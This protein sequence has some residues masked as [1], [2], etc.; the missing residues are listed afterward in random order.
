MHELA[1]LAVAYLIG[2][3]LFGPI[4]ARRLGLDLRAEGSG[5]PGATNMHRAAGKGPAAA[6]LVLDASK[7]ACGVLLAHFAAPRSDW[8]APACVLMACIGH[9]FP[10]QA[11]RSGGKGVSTALGGILASSLPAAML[12][13]LAYAVVRRVSGYGSVASLCA[14]IV[15]SV[16]VVIKQG[17]L[18]W[19]VST[20][21]LTLVALIFA[22]HAD[23]LRRL[24]NGT[25]L[26]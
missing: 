14:I 1:S 2:S 22:R 21:Y 4:I 19:A 3:I 24:A 25:E 23:N 9:C 13:G 7:G 15:G 16:V 17:H 5:N 11:T 8:L 20:P 18:T 6:V 12:A 26:R 10:L